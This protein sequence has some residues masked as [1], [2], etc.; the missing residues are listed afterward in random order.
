MYSVAFEALSVVI[1]AS[2]FGHLAGLCVFKAVVASARKRIATC[3][4]GS[5]PFGSGMYWRLGP[6]PVGIRAKLATV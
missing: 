1:A 2:P 4:G 6:L 5:F 3:P